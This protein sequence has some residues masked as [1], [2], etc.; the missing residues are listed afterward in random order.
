MNNLG[1]GG[2]PGMEEVWDRLLA[3]GKRVYGIAVDDAHYFK[4]PWDPLAP[5]PGRGWVVVR[6][7]RLDA[8]ALL[9]SLEN[10]DFYASTGVELDSYAAER[11]G[12]RGAG[13]YGRR[14]PLPDPASERAAS[15]CRRW[16][17]R[18][19]ALPWLDGSGYARVVVRD[20]NGAQA[21]MQPMFLP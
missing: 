1:G 13:A 17:A 18:R 9:A 2:A 6:A 19:P 7:P 14:H 21:W 16:M 3:A 4:R 10:G 11:V 5:R 20:S 12:N 8:A 15:W